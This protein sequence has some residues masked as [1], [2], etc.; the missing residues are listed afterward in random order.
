MLCK[1]CPAYT[2]EVAIVVTATEERGNEQEKKSTEQSNEIS[3]TK[4]SQ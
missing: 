3:L 4:N 2:G 1:V